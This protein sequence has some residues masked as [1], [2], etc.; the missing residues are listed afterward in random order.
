MSPKVSLTVKWSNSVYL[1]SHLAMSAGDPSP[2]QKF[3][4]KGYKWYQVILGYYKFYY[5]SL[6]N[7][8][9]QNTLFH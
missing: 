6:T 2:Y 5:I 7:L 1:V 4:I 3:E 9:T 8:Y